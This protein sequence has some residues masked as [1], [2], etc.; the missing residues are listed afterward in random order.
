MRTPYPLIILFAVYFLIIL[1]IAPN[2]MRNRKALEIK[3][4]IQCYNIFQI[5]A[6]TYFVIKFHDLG[7]NFGNMWKC[8]DD[9]TPGRE[10]ETFD[11]MW[12]FLMLRIVELV[13]TIFFIARKK[14]NQVS[15][16]HIYHHVSTIILLWLFFKYSAGKAS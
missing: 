14:L 4:L 5:A 3:R 6:C 1:K 8:V 16:L 7:F 11:R 15:A 10:N 2:F 9:L 12:W 13:E